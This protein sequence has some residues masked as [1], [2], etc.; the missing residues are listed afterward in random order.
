MLINIYNSNLEQ[1]EVARRMDL[2]AARA[3][4]VPRLRPGGIL[5]VGEGEGRGAEP[6]SGGGEGWRRQR[7]GRVEVQRREAQ[8]RGRVEAAEKGKGLEWH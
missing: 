3:L 2:P 6:G 7:R 8:R 5:V 1:I 4:L